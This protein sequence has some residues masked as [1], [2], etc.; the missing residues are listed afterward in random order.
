MT[1]HYYI[2][3]Y[4]NKALLFGAC[5]SNDDPVVNQGDG[6]E[7]TLNS[8]KFTI[9]QTVT[10]STEVRATDAGTTEEQQIGN[11][12]LFLFDNTGANPV[13]HYIDNATF[14]GGT[15][16]ATDKRIKLSMTQA[17][18]GNR[19]VYIV[20]NVS[21][22]LKSA[23]DASSVSSVTALSAVLETTE[24]PWSNNLTTPIL[25]SGSATHN[26]TTNRL[27]NAVELV[28]ALAK[29]ELN[30]T[31]GTKHQDADATLYQYNFI[32]FDKNTY[33]LANTTKTASKATSNWQAWQETGNVSTYTK[34]DSK[35]TSLTLVTYINE[36]ANAGSLID[37]QL[38]YNDGGLLPPPEFGPETF[39]LPLPDKIV[40]NTWYK[41]DIEI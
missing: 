21:S 22:T 41:Y 6:I 28:R 33:V 25:M 15:W 13:K 36:T 4:T 34:T 20:A 38:P 30:I 10:K 23:L 14:T 40:R 1:K 16:S 24:Q 31:L 29:V 12:Y 2:F 19:Q 35:V 7:I 37:I 27:L 11:L 8:A 18:A 17:E 9:K 32:D 39:Q 26:F 3:L 5:S